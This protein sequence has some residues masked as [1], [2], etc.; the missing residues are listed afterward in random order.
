MIQKQ[1]W[2]NYKVDVLTKIR[3]IQFKFYY[4]LWKKNNNKTET[5]EERPSYTLN[6]FK[7]NLR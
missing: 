5:A 1:F 6:G 2:Y 4:V 7:G 3:S